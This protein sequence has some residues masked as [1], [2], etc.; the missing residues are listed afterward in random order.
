M[1]KSTRGG[2]VSTLVFSEGSDFGPL[3]VDI[4]SL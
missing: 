1:L 4:D 2:P 3:D